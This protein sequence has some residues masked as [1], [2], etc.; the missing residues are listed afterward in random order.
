MT[1]A[2]GDDFRADLAELRHETQL[3]FARIDARFA[4]IDQKFA[5]FDQKFDGVRLEIREQIAGA[6]ATLLKWSFV[7]WV[8]AVGAI[9]GLAG[10]LK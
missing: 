2:R 7:F 8:S 10:V 4:T 1:R 3:G 5:T 6:T 9:A